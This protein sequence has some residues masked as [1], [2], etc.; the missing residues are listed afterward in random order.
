MILP[1]SFLYQVINE[2]QMEKIISVLGILLHLFK[3]VSHDHT[4]TV[5][6][7]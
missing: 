2:M 1:H 7:L 6:K 3:Y 4:T 5:R